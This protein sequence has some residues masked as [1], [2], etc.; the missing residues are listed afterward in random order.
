MKM[1]SKHLTLEKVGEMIPAVIFW[2][3]WNERNCRCLD[4][5]S[6]PLYTLKATCLVSLFSWSFLSPVNSIDNLMD[7][8]S[9]MVIV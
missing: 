2:V 3:I 5:I 7:F 1:K 8:V 6:T 4:G 9:S